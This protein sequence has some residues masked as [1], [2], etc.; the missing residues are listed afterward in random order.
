[1]VDDSYSRGV[2]LR[3][4]LSPGGNAMSNFERATAL[5]IRGTDFSETS[6]IATLW[7]REFGKLRAIAKGGRRLRS[8]FDNAFDLLTVCHVNFIRKSGGLD[9]LTEA[10]VAERFAHLRAD[11]PALYVGYYLAELLD[12][13]Q[14][15]D[16]HPVLFDATLALL[17][18]LGDAATDRL[19]GVT[20][21]ELVWLRELG[22][23][24]QLEACA[25]CDG[26]PLGGPRVGYSPAAGGVVC[27]ACLGEVRD[28]QALSLPAWAA[29]KRLDAGD[30][31][32][33][34]AEKREVRQALGRTVSYV[35]G[36][37]PKLLGYVDAP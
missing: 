1:M 13:T 19:A 5:V 37:R 25:A 34:G 16:P 24:P 9:L 30:A 2:P 6:K 33:L 7:T 12:A 29:L 35:L 3:L 22:Y 4:L 18:A 36:R 27:Q 15:Y 21:F 23:R 8:N 14:D 17:R 26:S 11:L 31:A 20:A 28:H 10:S 32:A